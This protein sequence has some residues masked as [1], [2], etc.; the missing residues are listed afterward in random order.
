MARMNGAIIYLI[1]FSGCGK[2]TIAKEIQKRIDCIVV[3]NH[4][5][6]NVIFSLID[7]DGKS[8]LPA[9][10]WNNVHRVRSAA[11]DTIRDLGKP[12]RIFVLTNVL[13]EGD[14]ED[15]LWFEEVVQLARDRDAH[16]L[17]VRLTITPEELARRV[18]SEGRAE[19]FK[20]TDPIAAIAKAKRWEVLRSRD[21]AMLEVDV[22]A[23]TADGVAAI[24]ID[25][26]HSTEAQS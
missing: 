22:S 24:V 19:Q 23:M 11:F 13:M 9:A 16:F 2:R 8:K 5:I 21:H 4:L 6:N 15:R 7:P 26:L 1:G 17:P 18:V 25:R 12:G 3:D 20:E 10:V 14:E